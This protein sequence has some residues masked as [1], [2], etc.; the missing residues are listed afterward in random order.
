MKRCLTP[1]ARTYLKMTQVRNYLYNE[2]YFK[3]KEVSCPVVSFG[4]LTAGGTGKTPLVSHFIQWAQNQEFKVGVVTRGYGGRLSYLCQQVKRHSQG[5]WLYGDEPYMLYLKHED[6]PIWI[7]TDRVR[8]AQALWNNHKVDLILADDAFQHRR[9]KRD[10]DILILNAMETQDNYQ[11][12]PLGRAREDFSE[13]HRA[14][15][16][17]LNKVNLASEENLIFIKEQLKKN[18]FILLYLS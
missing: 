10:M 1:L 15:A 9:L 18:Y 8:A 14:Q 13:I 2:G 12:L 6:V 16:I 11:P 7:C 5:A 17:I 4:N 3:T